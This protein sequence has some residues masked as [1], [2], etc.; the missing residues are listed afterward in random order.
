MV[1]LRGTILLVEPGRMTPEVVTLTTAHSV[2]G[3][4]FDTRSFPVS[5]L[6]PEKHWDS[7]NSKF[8]LYPKNI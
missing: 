3:P 7:K 6:H 5:K 4:D 2:R 8:T 1:K